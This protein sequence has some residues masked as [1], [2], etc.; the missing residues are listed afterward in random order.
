M[1]KPV[2]IDLTALPELL[3]PSAPPSPE[4][5]ALIGVVTNGSTGPRVVPTARPYRVTHELLQMA[6][7]V[8]PSEVFRFA[9][10]CRGVQCVHFRNE[11]CQLAARSVRLLEAVSEGLPA[12]PIRPKCRWFRQEGPAICKRCPQVITDQFRPTDHML[13]IVYGTEPCAIPN[14]TT[15]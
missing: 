14:E 13:E 12:C 5:S 8:G 11:A 2:C 4:E 9:A 3:C 7:P 6:E 15:T 1:E 10:A